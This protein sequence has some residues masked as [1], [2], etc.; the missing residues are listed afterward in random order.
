MLVQGA[1]TGEVAGHN[2]FPTPIVGSTLQAHMPTSADVHLY[3]DPGKFDAQTPLLYADCEGFEG[4]EKLPVGAIENRTS[5]LANDFSNGRLL[6]G[7]VRQLK[8][9]DTPEKQT[10]AHAV[11][12]LYPR[13][14]YTFSDVIV[15]VLKDSKYE[16]IFPLYGIAYQCLELSKSLRSVLCSNG[17]KHPWKRRSISPLFRTPSSL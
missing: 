4:G 12:Q 9:A 10:R 15:F 14:L 2:Q 13:I 11:S 16:F 6:P 7:H 1:D 5:G 8:W 3:A 17:E